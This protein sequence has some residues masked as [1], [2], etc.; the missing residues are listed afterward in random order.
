MIRSMQNTSYFFMLFHLVS[1]ALTCY[2]HRA[3]AR[4][5]PSFHRWT[6]LPDFI[7]QQMIRFVTANYSR[8]KSRLSVTIEWIMCTSDPDHGTNCCYGL[9]LL[10]WITRAELSWLTN[11]QECEGEQRGVHGSLPSPGPEAAAAMCWRSINMYRVPDG[12]CLVCQNGLLLCL[13]LFSLFSCTLSF[14][15]PNW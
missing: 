14:L 15:P 4:K 13:V 5:E 1:Y 10:Q 9:C 8:M 7:R 2:K 11:L 3:L 12:C 6:S